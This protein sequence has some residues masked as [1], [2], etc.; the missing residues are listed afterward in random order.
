MQPLQALAAVCRGLDCRARHR[1]L[2]PP[3]QQLQLNWVIL[4]KQHA[5]VAL[6][7]RREGRTRTCWTRREAERRLEVEQRLEVVHDGTALPLTFV[8]QLLG[9][10]PLGEEQLAPISLPAVEDEQKA[11]H[12]ESLE[13]DCRRSFVVVPAFVVPDFD[14]ND[15]D[16]DEPRE[17]KEGGVPEGEEAAAEP[18]VHGKEEGGGVAVEVVLGQDYSSADGGEQDGEGE[19]LVRLHG[20]LVLHRSQRVGQND[21]GCVNAATLRRVA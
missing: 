2:H 10:T 21:Y 6:P 17:C 5:R 1:L 13:P 12:E 7:V 19:V 8:D 16:S 9:E 3:F 14:G 18:E 20:A 15:G 11:R 4:H